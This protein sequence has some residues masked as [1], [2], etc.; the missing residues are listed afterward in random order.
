MQILNTLRFGALEYSED[1]VLYFPKGVPGFDD[2]KKWLLLGDDDE[3]NPIK[4]LQ[5]LKDGDVALPVMPPELI[6]PKYDPQLCESDIKDMTASLNDLRFFVVVAVP[7][8]APWDATANVRAP[9]VINVAKRLGKQVIGQR[10]D[11]GIRHYIFDD[12]TREKIKNAFLEA[13]R[14]SSEGGAP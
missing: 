2:H 6:I 12:A 3:G 11:Y 7:E 5:S 4:W 14:S 8:N 10:E 9:I 1:D 13:Q